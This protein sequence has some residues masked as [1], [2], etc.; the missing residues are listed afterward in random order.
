MGIV[1]TVFMLLGLSFLLSPLCW[2]IE[3]YKEKNSFFNFVVY[4]LLLAGLWNALWFG[5]RN[6]EIFWGVAALISGIFMVVSSLILLGDNNRVLSAAVVVKIYKTI[7][8]LRLLIILGLSGS[9]LLYAI[10]LIQLNLGY[11]I[12]H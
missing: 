12:I 6:L 3:K 11:P 4:G 10:T 9:F 7:K 5:L 8:P 2:N 1:V